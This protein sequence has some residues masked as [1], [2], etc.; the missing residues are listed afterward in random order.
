MD[1]KMLEEKLAQLKK[2]YNSIPAPF[3]A[4]NSTLRDAY[5]SSLLFYR[6]EIENTQSL[7][8]DAY[9]REEE[10]K[11][12]QTQVVEE[13][14]AEVAKDD[15]LEEIN[16]PE[17]IEDVEDVE[18]PVEIDETDEIDPAIEYSEEIVEEEE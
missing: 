2:E 15:V 13:K 18:E 16:E 8:N 7:L 12:A 5:A 17:I 6:Q 10:E 9:Q 4:P 11:E 1:I 3:T 14:A